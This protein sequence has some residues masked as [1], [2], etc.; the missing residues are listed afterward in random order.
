VPFC[1][2]CDNTTV[3]HQSVILILFQARGAQQTSSMWQI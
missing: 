3:S 2:C 1:R